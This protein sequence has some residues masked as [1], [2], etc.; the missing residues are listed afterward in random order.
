[1]LSKKNHCQIEIVNLTSF[2]NYIII[3]FKHCSHV[4]SKWMH[5]IFNTYPFAAYMMTRTHILF[6]WS[7]LSNSYQLTQ[8]LWWPLINVTYPKLKSTQI[9]ATSFLKAEGKKKCHIP[10]WHMELADPNPAVLFTQNG[11]QPSN[12]ITTPKL[13]SAKSNPLKFRWNV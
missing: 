13:K 8:V 4:T 1:M 6:H 10:T 11:R 2:S 9:Y 3:R 5:I 7:Q 12:T